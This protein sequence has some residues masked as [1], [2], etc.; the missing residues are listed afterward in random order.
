MSFAVSILWR[1]GFQSSGFC[2]CRPLTENSSRCLFLVCV[3]P[4]LQQC[5]LLVSIIHLPPPSRGDACRS[6]SDLSPHRPPVGT[7]GKKVLHFRGV[8]PAILCTNIRTILTDNSFYLPLLLYF[9]YH[10]I[11]NNT[12]DVQPTSTSKLLTYQ[13]F[14]LV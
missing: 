1:T 9:R 6:Q 10:M 3:H 4:D 2:V 14:A 7:W 13:I 11:S 8:I 12:R 5:A